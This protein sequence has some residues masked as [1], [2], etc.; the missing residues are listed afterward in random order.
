MAVLRTRRHRL[1]GLLKL[2][3]LVL[4]AGASTAAAP[5]PA[6]VLAR[7]GMAVTVANRQIIILREYDG[8]TYP[9]IASKLGINEAAV[10]M[11]LSRALNRLGRKMRELVDDQ[12]D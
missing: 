11:R 5:A 8:L 9:E 1:A 4:A 7:D 12:L 10:R 3:A 6:P 2:A